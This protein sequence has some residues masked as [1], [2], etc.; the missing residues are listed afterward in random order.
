MESSFTKELKWLKNY[1]KIWRECRRTKE[2]HAFLIGTPV[3]GNLGDQAITLGEYK[4]FGRHGISEK[5]DRDS[6]FIYSQAY[7]NV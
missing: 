6:I 3:Y 4:F 1:V 5:S 2:G 7:E